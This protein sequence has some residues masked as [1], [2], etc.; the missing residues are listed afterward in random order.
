MSERKVALV[1]GASAGIGAA[2]ARLL[3]RNGYDI[4]LHYNSDRAGVELVAGMAETDGAEVALIQADLGQPDDVARVFDEFDDAFGRLDALVNNAG[5]VAAATRVEDMDAA[6]IE[7]MF[8]VN[9]TGAFLVAGAAVRRMSTSH[10]GDGGVIVNMSSVSSRLASPNL[11]VDY[12]ASKAGLD[13]LTRG[14]ALEVAGDGIR[15]N[16]IRPGIIE[17]AI[18]AKGG[19][20]DR[21][22]RLAP[23]VPMGRTGSAE[24]VA[25]AVLWL[26][27]DAASYVTGST[28]DVAGGR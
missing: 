15:V 18:H 13:V 26:L 28:L 25:E 5:M 10:G 3:A 27:S 12:A 22:E 4:A 9:L 8:A 11:Y 7:R 1:T 21:A 23:T 20:P 19:D 17:T 2:T 24:E 16:G 6:R 14:L